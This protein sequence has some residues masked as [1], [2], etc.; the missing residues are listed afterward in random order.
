MKKTL[1]TLAMAAAFVST[2][3]FA[4]GTEYQYGTSSALVFGQLGKVTTVKDV[5]KHNDFGLGAGVGLGEVIM[6]NGHAYI[7]GPKGKGRELKSSDGLSYMTATEFK[8]GE[9]FTI[10]NVPN[11]AALQKQIKLLEKND[12][13]MYAIKVTGT[14]NNVEARSENYQK[15]PYTPLVSWMKDNQN[16]YNFK[17]TKGTLVIFQSPKF[18]DGIGVPGFHTHFVSNNHKQVGHVFDVN[19]KN[20]TVQIQTLNNLKL[21]LRTTLAP[22]VKHGKKDMSGF[23]RLETNKS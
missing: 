16:V 7:A 3:S 19:I 17:N 9:T 15:P 18:M 8:G 12:Q 21:S 4:Q 14:F 1:T 2:A 23:N 20:A 10:K 11:I 13:L 5:S 6:V 22:V